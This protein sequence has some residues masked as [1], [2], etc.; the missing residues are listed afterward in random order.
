MRTTMRSILFAAATTALAGC[1]TAPPNASC[2]IP[3]DA[4]HWRADYCLSESET[5]D[6]IAAQPCMDRESLRHFDD[7]CAAKRYYKRAL[8]E[9]AVRH[10]LRSGSVE[11]CV[12]DAAF[13]G[14]TVANGGV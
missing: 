11:Q 10:E 1:A 7:S 4:V 6:I 12:N 13:V 5:D 3:G 2:A 9:A 8:C 14:T